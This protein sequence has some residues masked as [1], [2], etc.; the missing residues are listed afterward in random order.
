MRIQERTCIARLV[1][2]SGASFPDRWGTGTDGRYHAI[3][4]TTRK[5]PPETGAKTDRVIVHGWAVTITKGLY[6]APDSPW[7]FPDHGA[8]MAFAT[9]AR[10]SMQQASRLL[11]QP[12]CHLV[13]WCPVHKM[14]EAVLLVSSDIRARGTYGD[15]KLI[16]SWLQEKTAAPPS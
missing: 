9:A 8:A 5:F 6:C 2:G 16:A 7:F 10:E 12:A 1:G 14:D 15:L 13:K 4:P 3:V 11:I